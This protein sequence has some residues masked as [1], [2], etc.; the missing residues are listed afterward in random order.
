MGHFQAEL[1][2]D[3]RPAALV[4]FVFRTG[5]HVQVVVVRV[6]LCLQESRNLGSQRRRPL[7]TKQ[8]LDSRKPVL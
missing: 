2:Q 3:H 4:T 7:R 1:V 6:G 8:L 5:N